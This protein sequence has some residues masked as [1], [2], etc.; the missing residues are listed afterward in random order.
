[1][2]DIIYTLQDY[3]LHT[4]N[5]T[6]IIMGISLIGVV[7]FWLFLTGTQKNE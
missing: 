7:C 4:E 2:R 1:M 5:I 6:Y 3:M